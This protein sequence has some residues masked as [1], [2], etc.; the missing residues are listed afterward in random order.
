MSNNELNSKD[1]FKKFFNLK[2]GDYPL[3]PKPATDPGVNKEWK[4]DTQNNKWVTVSNKTEPL[5]NTN[6]TVNNQTT[7]VNNGVSTYDTG[8]YTKAGIE[9]LTDFN[10]FTTENGFD[11][12]IA[13]QAT[14]L[15][16]DKYP[17]VKDYICS[18]EFMNDIF[19]NTREEYNSACTEPIQDIDAFV[20]EPYS[21]EE[22]LDIGWESY[23]QYRLGKALQILKSKGLYNFDDGAYIESSEIYEDIDTGKYPWVLTDT[24]A[25]SE[26]VPV[27]NEEVK[28]I[29]ENKLFSEDV[30]H[31]PLDKDYR[32]TERK[33]LR[34]KRDKYMKDYVKSDTVEEDISYNSSDD[35]ADMYISDDMLDDIAND[36]VLSESD[37][38]SLI[39][40]SKKEIKSDKKIDTNRLTNEIRDEIKNFYK[41]SIEEGYNPLE[42]VFIEVN[43]TDDGRIR[44]EVR[45]EAGYNEMEEL[46]EVL[47]K[48]IEKYDHYA[49]FDFDDV[50]IMSAYIEIK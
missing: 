22:L 42:N 11:Y 45:L 21:I 34:K 12:P 46:A 9:S 3:S 30:Y 8:M 33:N 14:H 25:K 4:W 49:Y 18:D 20:N 7:F 24:S 2:A 44:I 32:E 43:N 23:K 50:G 13:I 16:T 37:V 47:N 15:N 27:T 35:S 28:G 1:F 40:G 29:F 41:D 10:N 5:N 26:V 39:R 36:G 31:L 17:T 38:Q 48:I 6:N 19:V